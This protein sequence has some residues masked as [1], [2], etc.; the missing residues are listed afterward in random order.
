MC[1]YF[2]QKASK[3]YKYPVSP[4][5]MKVEIENSQRN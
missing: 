4:I 2:E 3:I 5:K 1:M